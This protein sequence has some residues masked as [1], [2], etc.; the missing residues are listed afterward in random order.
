MMV[1]MFYNEQ[2]VPTDNEVETDFSDLPTSSSDQ[3]QVSLFYLKE[4]R[5]CVGL[6]SLFFNFRWVLRVHMVNCNFTLT[7]KPTHTD[8]NISDPPYAAN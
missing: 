1:K 4:N 6:L 8:P 7:F 5:R 2:V 3:V